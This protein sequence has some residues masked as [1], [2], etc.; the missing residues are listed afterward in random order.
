MAPKSQFAALNPATNSTAA[1]K[2]FPRIVAAVKGQPPTHYLSI[3]I[4]ITID[5]DGDGDGDGED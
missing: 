4:V 5:A 2:P 1:S 3:P